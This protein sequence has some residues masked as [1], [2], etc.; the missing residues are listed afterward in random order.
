HAL[1]Q[2]GHNRISLILDSRVLRDQE[3]NERRKQRFASL[4]D[5]VHELEE[6]QVER[7]FLLRN[8]PM[9][10]KP[11]AQQ[12]PEALHRIPI[13][14]TQ[15]VALFISGQFP[16]SM[17]DTL[18]RVSPDIQASINAVF[19][20]INKCT[21]HDGVFDQGLDGLLLDIG[22]Q[23]DDHLTTALHHPKDRGAFLL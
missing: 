7:E 15:A 14:F 21:W 3:L 19:V 5:V 10:T 8:T 13:H 16:P 9:W 6:A 4:A 18:M 22:Q 20:G 2:G 11:T 1:R 23:I 17:I 12:R